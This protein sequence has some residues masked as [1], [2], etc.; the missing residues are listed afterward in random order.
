LPRRGAVAFARRCAAELATR[1]YQADAEA[2][3]SVLTERERAL[4]RL[5]AA[6][7][8][9]QEIAARLFVG[10]KTVEYHLAQIYGKLGITSRRQLTRCAITSAT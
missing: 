2:Q 1:R 9:N 7:L 8:T 10:V 4:A 5:V 6:G 3:L